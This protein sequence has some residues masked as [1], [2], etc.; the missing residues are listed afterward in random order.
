MIRNSTS[1]LR[2]QEKDNEKELLAQKQLEKKI[3]EEK[4]S[5]ENAGKQ[6][7]RWKVYTSG[8]KRLV[9]KNEREYNKKKTVQK[10]NRKNKK[11]K[12]TK[13]GK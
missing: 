2:K 7:T 10:N 1:F 9:E 5:R 13:N 3:D 12:D 11:T 4:K 6:N 8:K